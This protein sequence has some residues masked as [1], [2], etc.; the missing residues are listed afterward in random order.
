MA[1]SRSTGKVSKT[2]R[3]EIIIPFEDVLSDLET[4]QNESPDG[5]TT[6]EM[7]EVV[8]KS[9]AW[10]SRKIGRLI[11]AGLAEFAGDRPIVKMNR[12]RGVVP[13][14]RLIEK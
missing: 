14:Y 10:C 7:S 4:L 12:H 6:R 5:F 8:G 3:K 1:S 11:E 2:N 13:V 9:R